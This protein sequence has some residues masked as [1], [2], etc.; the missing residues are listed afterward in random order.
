[1]NIGMTLLLFTPR[2]DDSMF[3]MA[4]DLKKIGYDGLEWPLFDLDKKQAKKIGSFNK[5]NGLEATTIMVLGPGS[6]PISADKKERANAMTDIKKRIDLS[7]E[8]GSKLLCGPITQPLGHFSGR[9]RTADEWKRCVAFF[10][11]AGEIAE[12]AGV[13]LVLEYLNRF[14][15]YFINTAADTAQLCKEIGHK[16]VRSMIDTFHCNIEEKSFYD[17]VI[18][19]KDHLV[20]VHI[21]ENDR[22]TPGVGNN[23][24]WD[25][26]FRGL[27]D[28]KYDG[29]LMIEAFSQFL[30]DLSAAAKIWRPLIEDPKQ[31]A[32]QGYAFLKKM[33][34]RG[35]K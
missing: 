15:L 3:H 1:M 7:V 24:R 2:P 14:E 22:S 32:K 13:T 8:I 4:E 11:K 10:Q 26:F 6:S 18:A 17:P 21:S 34:G 16:R 20:H 5:A 19:L 30:P 12:K 33:T 23:I 27:K 35:K 9:A 29:W 31:T 28:V 25:D